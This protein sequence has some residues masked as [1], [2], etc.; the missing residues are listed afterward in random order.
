VEVLQLDQAID[1]QL[2]RRG[3]FRCD[4][5]NA[6]LVARSG[7]GYGGRAKAHG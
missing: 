4:R 6:L 3:G 2:A 1:K 5:E 7:F